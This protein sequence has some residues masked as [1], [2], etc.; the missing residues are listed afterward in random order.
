[1]EK[2][3]TAF[4]NAISGT[5]NWVWQSITFEVPWYTN[6]FWGLILISLLVWGLEL[7]FP[8]RKEQK[9]FRKDFWMDGFYMFLIFSFSLLLLQVSTQF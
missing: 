6:Y 2:Y 7:S 4:T 9:A 1:M 8:W 5:L 3:I